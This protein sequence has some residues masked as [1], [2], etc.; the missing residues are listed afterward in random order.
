QSQLTRRVSADPGSAAEY[1]AAE[2]RRGAAGPDRRDRRRPHVAEHAL[3]V[4]VGAA[5]DHAPVAEEHHRAPGPR[6][7][8]PD[9]QVIERHLFLVELPDVG[10]ETLVLVGDDVERSEEHT[11]ELQSL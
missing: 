11:S 5:A 7:R 8:E 4:G 1:V 10:A 2:A 6:T 3:A 9:R